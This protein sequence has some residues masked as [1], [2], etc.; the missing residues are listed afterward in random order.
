[1]PQVPIVLNPNSPNQWNTTIPP[2]IYNRKH[3]QKDPLYTGATN[4]NVLF[5]KSSFTRMDSQPSNKRK[6]SELPLHTPRPAP[7]L[8]GPQFFSQ[9]F[10]SPGT[11][12]KTG[13]ALALEYLASPTPSRA[14]G[15]P[16]LLTLETTPK[17]RPLTPPQISTTPDNMDVFD[18]M[19]SQKGL[20]ASMHA[21]DSQ[22]LAPEPQTQAPMARGP[23]D[24]GDE[25]DDDA[26]LRE[27]A[28][29]TESSAKAATASSRSPNL[30]FTLPPPEGF[31]ITYRGS[32]AEFML[33]LAQD[34][35]IAWRTMAEPKFF[36]R[37]YDYDGKDATKHQTL[38][39]K[40]QKSLEIIAAH[41]GSSTTML[42]ISPPVAPV[43][44]APD[45]TPPTTFLV[46]GASQLLRKIVVEQRVWSV[47]Q[48]TFEA[49]P[50]ESNVIPTIILCLAGFIC[51]D[52]DTVT[53]SV[54]AAWL[55]PLP[56]AQLAEIL[57]ATDRSFSGADAI[58]LARSAIQNMANS[59]QSELLNYR[60]PGG[61][62]SPRWNIYVTPP[63][64]RIAAWTKLK[65]YVDELIYPSTLS[66]TGT[67]RKLFV[68]TI[69]HSRNHPRGLCPF[70][71][72]QG[73]NGP[74]H[75]ERSNE[76]AT[77]E[78]NRGRGRNWTGA[79]RQPDRARYPN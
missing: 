31:P 33:N 13:N 72:T 68:C 14:P 45:A 40:L 69:C 42:K 74:Q 8:N 37:F 10:A 30:H 11:M 43:P 6:A 58:T 67:T 15:T 39:L 28:V 46:Y 4:P 61:A 48:V 5:S 32:A 12:P 65:T 73:W 64:A 16:T 53:N 23:C 66:G 44:A 63:T 77:R 36:V 49:Y 34:T 50:F 22:M 62:P 19:E 55:Q 59:A 60:T 24:D 1:M 27:L 18:A 26:F 78:F 29:V 25:D 9:N 70:P 56:K 47:P 3:P 57:V 20:D 2:P 75:T 17:Q 35:V 76:P 38:V 79:G 7:G 52:D 54:K 21:P 51:P 71:D 41:A